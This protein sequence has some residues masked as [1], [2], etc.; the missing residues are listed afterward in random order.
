[1][2]TVLPLSFLD[3][4]EKLRLNILE[5]LNFIDL[6]RGSRAHPEIRNSV[7]SMLRYEHFKIRFLN[8]ANEIEIS[9]DNR[10]TAVERIAYDDADFDDGVF[11]EI[12][13]FF[14]HFGHCVTKLTYQYDSCVHSWC[15][16]VHKQI[17]KY[18]ARTVTGIELFLNDKPMN[19][20]LNDLIVP[21]PNV[22]NA[23]IWQGTIEAE[24]V[25]QMFP[26]VQSLNLMCTI[27]RESLA[28][29][30]YLER[31]ST[32]YEWAQNKSY[33]PLFEQ[34]FA[35]N[36]QLKQLTVWES[37]Y[38][39]FLEMSPTQHLFSVKNHFRSNAGVQCLLADA[40]PWHSEHN[41][42]TEENNST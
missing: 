14:Q 6:M 27:M 10:C 30:P 9:Y 16:Q 39:D 24:T 23:K 19:G 7:E 8:D 25:H 28:H 15:E 29:F 2:E 37:T 3:L 31:L 41:N 4:P 38:W 21:F 20:S 18:V 11:E 35:L 1:M 34:T 12:S 22:I 26:A 13:Y 32:P 33:L 36:P 17:G 5:R 42:S 40:A